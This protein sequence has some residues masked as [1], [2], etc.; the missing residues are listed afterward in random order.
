MLNFNLAEVDATFKE[1]GMD[2]WLR[3]MQEVLERVQE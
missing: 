1:M 2:Y 3:R